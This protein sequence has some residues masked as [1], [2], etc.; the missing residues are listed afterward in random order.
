M[1]NDF[2][3]KMKDTIVKGANTVAGES[4]KLVERGKIKASVMKLEDQKK[5]LLMELGNKY[6][7]AYK[8]DNTNSDEV[9]QI[10]EQLD[11]LHAEIEIKKEE[12]ERL[13]AEDQKKSLLM[14]LGNKYYEAYKQDN[15]NSDEVRQIC[16]Q[17]DTLHAEIE[18][19][20]E[21]NERL[22]AEE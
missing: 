21:E 6:Y 20:K 12:N 2:F 11:T 16:E 14:E 7:E 18:I 5:S 13:K 8:Q 19:K 9:R 4:G 3:S 10:C 15:T 22:K 1:A 17:L